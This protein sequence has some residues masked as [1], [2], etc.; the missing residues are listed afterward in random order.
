MVTAHLGH[1][2]LGKGDPDRAIPLLEQAVAMMS[3]FRFRRLQ[4][5]GL[6]F[7][8]EG[9]LARGQFD[10]ARELAEEGLR[11]AREARYGYNMAWAQWVLGRIA[12]AGGH[13]A[14]A[15]GHLREALDTFTAVGR[16][17]HGRARPPDAGRGRGEG[18]SPR[19]RRPGTWRK[20]SA[21]FGP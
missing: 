12:L 11:L 14:D 20:P 5:R 21:P 18:R 17:V 8:G 15:F 3:Q 10:R 4:G 16:Q 2:Y 13:A 1:A 6:T 19:A 9:Y 7:L